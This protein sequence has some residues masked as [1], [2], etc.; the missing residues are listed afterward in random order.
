MK[1]WMQS[2]AA[3][4]EKVILD[5]VRDSDA[6]SLRNDVGEKAWDDVLI[7][8]SRGD[9]PLYPF[10]KKDIGSFYWLPAEAYDIAYP[11]TDAMSKELTV[12]SWVLPQ[13]G[14]TKSDN[15][16]QRRYP[17]ERW[18]R[19][20]QHG[21]AFNVALAKHLVAELKAAGIDAVVP[22]QLAAWS[23][24]ASEK[25][26]LASNWSERHAAYAAGLGTFG[27]SDGLITARGKAMRCGSVVARVDIP[28]TPRPYQDH[29]AY[30]L[31]YTKRA[32]KKCISRCPVGA[33][34]ERGHDKVKCKAYLYET[35]APY[36]KTHFGLESYG[37][38][39]CQTGVPCESAIPAA[40]GSK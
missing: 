16:R 20:R 8:F 5:Y 25:R 38:G 17:S 19:S 10:Y 6:N 32:C 3:W 13:R 33:I 23:Y 31:Y 28:P 26:G 27:L 7:G 30:C 18:V 2:K 35:L 9:D 1:E 4:I 37:C 12:I 39:L 22:S 21:E 11:G 34:D 36:S 40:G 15:Q 14:I 29:H 24:Q